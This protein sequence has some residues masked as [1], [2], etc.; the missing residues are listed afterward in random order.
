ME[1]C[2]QRLCQELR[3][4]IC[5]SKGMYL[6]MGVQ[7]HRQLDGEVCETHVDLL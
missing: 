4:T 1:E 3:G 2:D 6:H 5:P 7:G